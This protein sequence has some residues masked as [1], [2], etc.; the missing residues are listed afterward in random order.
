MLGLRRKPERFLDTARRSPL[1]LQRFLAVSPAGNIASTW[2]RRCSLRRSCRESP[3]KCAN[4][5]HVLGGAGGTAGMFSQ[6]SYPLRLGHMDPKRAGVAHPGLGLRESL[7]S[8]R[9]SQPLG[10]NRS[11]RTPGPLEPWGW[12]WGISAGASWRN[13]GPRSGSIL[14]GDLSHDFPVTFGCGNCRWS[15]SLV[16]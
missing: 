3:G 4:C 15:C 1:L 13:G 12:G 5:V 8:P 2:L 6:A 7:S 11:L 16:G 14:C 10:Y 9:A